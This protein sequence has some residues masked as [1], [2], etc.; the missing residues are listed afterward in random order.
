M[1]DLLEGETGP[2]Q[3]DQ[4]PITVCHSLGALKRINPGLKH[5]RTRTAHRTQR[6]RT[7]SLNLLPFTV[8][9]L[10][11]HDGKGKHTISELAP[12]DVADAS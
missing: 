11:I 2:R 4:L 8:L 7:S 9:L 10:T 5:T 12:V 1:Q 3:V 6:F